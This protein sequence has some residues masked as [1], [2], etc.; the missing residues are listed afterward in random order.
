MLVEGAREYYMILYPLLNNGETASEAIM[1]KLPLFGKK[2]L[3]CTNFPH[4][5]GTSFVSPLSKVTRTRRMTH[6]FLRAVFP[7]HILLCTVLARHHLTI[8]LLLLF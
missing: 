8:R 5:Y 2:F 3:P 1:S 7:D 6:L 4:V